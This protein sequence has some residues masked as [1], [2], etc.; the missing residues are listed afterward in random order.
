MCSNNPTVFFQRRFLTMRHRSFTETRSGQNIYEG[1]SRVTALL[2]SQEI[3]GLV[4]A[5][6]LFMAMDEPA[7]YRLWHARIDVMKAAAAGVA[8]VAA[9]TGEHFDRP[10]AEFAFDPAQT[11]HTAASVRA[12]LAEGTPPIIAGGSGVESISFSRYVLM[13]ND[14]DRLGTANTREI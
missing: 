13:E 7:L 2:F 8:G 4:A 11:T 12:A 6:E 3:M 10:N 9:T 14:K 5:V 1:N